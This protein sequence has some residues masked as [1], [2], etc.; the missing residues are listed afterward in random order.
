MRNDELNLSNFYRIWDDFFKISAN[1]FKSLF[2]R[3]LI[4]KTLD[5]DVKI[6]YNSLILPL[7]I[8]LF[9]VHSSLASG[10]C[11][12]MFVRVRGI[13]TSGTTTNE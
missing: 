11:A 2:F 1:I 12:E 6:C 3:G 7:Q 4:E 9:Q 10:N 5:S 13:W 8:P